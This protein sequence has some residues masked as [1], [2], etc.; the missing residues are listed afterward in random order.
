MILA[1]ELGKDPLLRQEIRDRY[2]SEALITVVPTERGIN[3]IDENHAYF[4]RNLCQGR[5]GTYSFSRIL[6]IC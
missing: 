6:N 1:T 5:K 4:V 3:K 2:K